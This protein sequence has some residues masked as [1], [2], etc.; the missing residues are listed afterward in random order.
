MPHQKKLKR[1]KK[2][3]DGTYV[4]YHSRV[5]WAW[6]LKW[7]WCEWNGMFVPLVRYGHFLLSTWFAMPG[8]WTWEL[9][10]RIA[11][12]DQVQRQ[13]QRDE[14]VRE[15][16]HLVLDTLASRLKELS[17]DCRSWELSISGH[18]D[19]AYIHPKYCLYEWMNLSVKG[20]RV[21]RKSPWWKKENILCNSSTIWDQN[22]K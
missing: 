9:C 12:S 2:R 3:L 17:L 13:Q 6:Y 15:N 20:D 8:P 5:L 22:G 14:P 11:S 7:D 18:K 1:Q 21:P 19:P 4:R 10:I 16:T